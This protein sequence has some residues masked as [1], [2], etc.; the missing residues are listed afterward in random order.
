MKTAFIHLMKR[1]LILPFL[2][3]ALTATAQTQINQVCYLDTTLIESSVFKKDTSYAVREEF[4]KGDWELYYDFGLQKKKAEW[5]FSDQGEQVGVWREWYKNGNKKSEFY[6]E[7]MFYRYLPVGKKWYAD[8]KVQTERFVRND[9]IVEN[10]FFKNGSLQ[11][12]YFYDKTGTMTRLE[13]WCESGQ[14]IV[15]FNP[16]SQTAEAVKKYHCNGKLKTE[17]TWYRFG[18]TGAF[19]DYFSNGQVAT[20]GQFEALPGNN[21]T[22]IPRKTGVWYV[23]NDKGKLVREEHYERGRLVKTVKG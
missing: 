20:K 6:Y 11:N 10:H 2:V 3:V 22:F 13:E 18:Y 15:S 21:P 12:R 17:Y 7:N 4:R 9:S 23:Y 1:F 19:T 14:Q 5:H 16:S 8:G